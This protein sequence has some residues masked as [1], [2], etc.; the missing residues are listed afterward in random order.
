[1]EDKTIE[2]VFG[3]GGLISQFHDAY[4]YREGQI[5][6]ADAIATAFIDKGDM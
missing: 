4:E 6:M 1:M 2:N 3:N 5:R